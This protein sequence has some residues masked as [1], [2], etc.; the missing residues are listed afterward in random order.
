MEEF[1]AKCGCNCSNCPSYKENLKTIIARKQCS[2]G[3]EKYLAI[4]LKPEKLRLCDG[5]AISD[6]NRN[7]YYL[8]CRVRKCAILSGVENCAYCSAY[9]CQD[10]L[11]IHSVQ[12]PNARE[13]IEERIGYRIP[14]KDYIN[15]VEPYEGIIHLD[16]IRGSLKSEDIKEMIPISKVL[17]T[18]PFPEIIPFSICEKSAYQQIHRIISSIEVGENVSYARYTELEKNRKKLLKLLWA[19]GLFGELEKRGKYIILDSKKYSEQKIS[20]YH[21]KV[22]EY[23][24]ILKG[25]GLVIKIISTHNKAWR[26]EK[27]ALR[28]EGWFMGMFSKKNK[29]RELFKALKKYT[30]LIDEKYGKN[31]FRYFTNGDMRVLC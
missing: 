26:T 31:A 15:I 19:F 11:T 28:Y 23:I 30:K 21:E 27:G 29:D 18:I 14:Q 1:I 25:Y 2:W 6:K 5:C 4:K 16:K 7:I 12:K 9:P 22:Q 10:V 13:R 8:N 17:K 20:S 3:W 24:Q